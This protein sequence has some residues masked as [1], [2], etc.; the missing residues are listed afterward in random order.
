MEIVARPAGRF[1]RS[2]LALWLPIGAVAGL[3]TAW[4]ATVFQ[5]DFNYAPWLLFPLLTGLALAAMLVAA[6]RVFHIGHRSTILLGTIISASIAIVGQHYFMYRAR[7]SQIAR[8]AEQLDAKEQ[9][10]LSV[11]APDRIPQ[12]PENMAEYLSE[13]RP[14]WG[15]LV[16]RG[17]VAWATWGIDALLT[18]AAAVAVVVPASRLPYCNECN[19]WYRTERSVRIEPSSANRLAEIAGLETEE[20]AKSARYRISDCPAHCGSSFLELSW[21]VA[22]GNMRIERAWLDSDARKRA[23]EELE[24]TG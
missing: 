20:N 9:F 15:G 7:A 16:A 17:W 1:S 3:A 2:K 22:T 8:Q 14:L 23:T 5:T 10:A 19:K 18:V 11:V 12:P 4:A 6:M 21:E 13:G 24:A